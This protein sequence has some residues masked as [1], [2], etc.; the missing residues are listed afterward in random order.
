MTILF[1][2]NAAGEFCVTEEGLDAIWPVDDREPL[3]MAEL[4]GKGWK[5]PPSC[6]EWTTS[7]EER[8]AFAFGAY[9]PDPLPMVY[10]GGGPLPIVPLPPSLALSIVAVSTLLLFKE[11]RKS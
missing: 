11:R 9:Q 8:L 4:F 7:E 2:T 3:P 5:L 10:Y 6:G 1:R